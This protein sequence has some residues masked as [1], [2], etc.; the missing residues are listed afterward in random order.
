M[1]YWLPVELLQNYSSPC[2]RIPFFLL[3]AKFYNANCTNAA[4]VSAML[5]LDEPSTVS[6]L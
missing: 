4:I 2:G 1:V 6:T 5:A 3:S